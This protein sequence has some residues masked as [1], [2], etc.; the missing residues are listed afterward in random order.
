MRQRENVSINVTGAAL[1]VLK[2]L[3]EPF[4]HD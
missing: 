1:K 3:R 2:G 4:G